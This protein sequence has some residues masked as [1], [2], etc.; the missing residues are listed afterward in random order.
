ME[1]IQKEKQD[2]I[3]HHCLENIGSVPKSGMPYNPLIT[4]GILHHQQPT[5]HKGET[6]GKGIILLDQFKLEIES[7]Q[8]SKECTLK[9]NKGIQGRYDPTWQNF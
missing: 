1:E 5:H 4:S 8:I 9:K 7:N 2:E 6:S 3:D